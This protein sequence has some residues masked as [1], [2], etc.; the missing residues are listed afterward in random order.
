MLSPKRGMHI[1]LLPSG[2]KAHYG[3]GGG[4]SVRARGGAHHEE[5]VFSIYD[6]AAAHK[7]S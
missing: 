4:K 2:L 5:P 1:S 7:D 6:R 3:R